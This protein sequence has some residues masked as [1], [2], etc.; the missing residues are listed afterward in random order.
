MLTAPAT[1]VDVVPG[2][3][4]V[5]PGTATVVEVV[6]DVLNLLLMKLSATEPYSVP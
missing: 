2:V 4:V 1:G 6:V 5:V 3:A